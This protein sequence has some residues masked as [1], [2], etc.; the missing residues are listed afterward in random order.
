M[1]KVGLQYRNPKRGEDMLWPITDKNLKKKKAVVEQDLELN[2]SEEKTHFSLIHT[3]TPL[4]SFSPCK[5]YLQG[6]WILAEAQ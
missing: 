4:T 3:S 6:S 1:F 2:L 5:H